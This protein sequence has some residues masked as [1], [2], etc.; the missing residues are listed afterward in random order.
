M[1][2]LRVLVLAFALSACG[3]GVSGSPAYVTVS[4]VWSDADALPKAT[5]YCDYYGKV[6]RFRFIKDHRATFDCVQG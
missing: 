1:K 4:N 3:Q 6:P 5:A 2:H